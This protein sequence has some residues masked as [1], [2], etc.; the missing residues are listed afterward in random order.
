MASIRKRRGAFSVIYSYTN[1]EGE[2]KQRWET[3]STYADAHKRRAEIEYKQN[4]GTF[5][6]PNKQTVAD[7]LAD[8][9]SL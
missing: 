2:K 1:D 3:F 5:L 6:P 9:V 7:F 4:E 8:F